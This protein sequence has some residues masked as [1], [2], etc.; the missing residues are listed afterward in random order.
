M[1][2]CV[3]SWVAINMSAAACGLFLKYP[4]K[5]RMLRQSVCYAYN[6]L[7][8]QKKLCWPATA[9]THTHTTQHK[10]CEWWQKHSVNP[11]VCLLQNTLTPQGICR[12]FV[13]RHQH[14]GEEIQWRVK[15][16]K[17]N[18]PLWAILNASA[19]IQTTKYL[20]TCCKY[21]Q[22]VFTRKNTG[23]FSICFCMHIAG[24]SFR[25]R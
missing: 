22:H 11:H 25:C 12:V 4:Y 8:T 19:N 6:V 21:K 16:W 5:G 18:L 1:R 14:H 24:V 15:Q 2:A 10:N 7:Q 17:V 20:Y 13:L 23:M 3:S 9:L